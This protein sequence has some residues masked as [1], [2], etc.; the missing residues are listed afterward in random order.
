[1]KTMTQFIFVAQLRSSEVKTDAAELM[2]VQTAEYKGER[3]LKLLY[4]PHTRG[5]NS[6]PQ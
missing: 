1:M 2:I 5:K 3:L 4:V 6:K